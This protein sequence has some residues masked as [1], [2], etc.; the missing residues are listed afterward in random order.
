MFEELLAESGSK[1]AAAAHRLGVALRG[2][3]PAIV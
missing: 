3:G 1:Y 2:G